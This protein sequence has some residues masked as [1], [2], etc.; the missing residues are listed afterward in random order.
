[1]THTTTIE[2]TQDQTEQRDAFVERLLASVGGAFDIFTLH[3]G[4]RLGFY[5]ALAGTDSMTSTELAAE[6]GTQERYVREWLEQQTVTG[7]LQVQNPEDGPQARRFSL[8]PAHTEVLTDINSPNY[9]LPLAPM[10]AG[11][12]R[13]I[14]QLLKAFQVGGGVP[15]SE[16]GTDFRE[17]QGAINRVTF[18]EDLP[19]EWLP[20]IPDIYER[21]Q[22]DLPT[23]VA[24]IG[25]GAGW[26]SIGIAKKYPQVQVDG[27]DLDAPSVEMAKRNARDAD[28]NGTVNFH[29][30]DAGDPT[31][32]GQY[33]LVLALE[34]IHDVSDPVA[35]LGKMRQLA[36]KNGAV[37]VADERVGDD[38]TPNGND[39]EWMMY[40]WSVLHCL[41]VG[42]ADMPSAATGTVMRTKN[43]R[44]YALEAGFREVEVL[45]IDNFFFR[46]YR[47]HQ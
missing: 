27:F 11:V 9:I 29:V 46:I 24:D 3:I 13:P 33:D 30:R 23:R 35:V 22:D 31:L 43:L 10:I 17:G 28:L 25:M 8:S 47:L 6:T 37:I 40:G 4:Y 26:S 2:L 12:V 20:A 7:I 44:E 39:V 19:N 21:L 32:K 16:Y 36:G 5:D 1:M 18:L 42:M 14:E 45:P 41:P 15:Y 38:F 34:C